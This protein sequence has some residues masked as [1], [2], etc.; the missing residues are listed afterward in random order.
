METS[1]K[2]NDY[3]EVLHVTQPTTEGVGKIVHALVSHQI[4]LGLKVAV[5]SP[6]TPEFYEPLLEMGCRWFQWSVTGNPQVNARA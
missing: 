2:A 3:V 4:A 5:A 1:A 6:N